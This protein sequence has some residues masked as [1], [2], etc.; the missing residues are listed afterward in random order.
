[1]ILGVAIFALGAR[2]FWIGG[3]AGIGVDGKGATGGGLLGI[4]VG[5]GAFLFPACRELGR[6]IARELRDYNGW[7]AELTPAQ[8]NAVQLAE[9]AAIVGS[10]L[11][12][13]EAMHRHHVAAGERLTQSVMGEPWQ[14]P[15]A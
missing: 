13:H 8:R 12:A 6:L 15:F 2:S 14:D 5:L 3:T 4:A 1:M 11:V 9:T 10:A 7:K